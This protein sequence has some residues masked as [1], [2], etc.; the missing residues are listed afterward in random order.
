MIPHSAKPWVLIPAFEPSPDLLGCVKI[1]LE[2]GVFQQVVLVNDG[3][4][5][6]SVEMFKILSLSPE[7][8]VLTHAVN[9]GKGQALK[10]GLN[11]YL[12]HS[13][14]DSPGLVT[15]DADGQHL[16]EDIIAVTKAGMASDCF[17]LGVRDFSHGVPWRSRL[18]NILTR[19]I[20]RLFTGVKVK[21]TQTGLR[22]IPRH[23]VGNHIC[24][25]HDRFEYEFA[26]LVSE[27]FELNEKL[28]QVPISTVYIH[29]NRS[30]HFHPIRDSLA[31][32][33]V[34]L[35]F[36]SLSFIS[37]LLD[38]MVFSV[39]FFL[40]ARTLLSFI[41]ARTV[42]VT[43][44]FTFSRRWVFRVRHEFLRQAVKYLFTVFILMFFTYYVTF[45][46]AKTFGTHV[47]IGKMISEGGLFV[48]SYLI[49][50]VFIFKKTCPPIS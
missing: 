28:A 24:I 16:T 41:V 12:I 20:F 35:K 26:V 5:A 8:T 18:G 23:R 36:T 38:Y 13:H 31:I 27:S 21:D 2:S 1:L 6:S 49:Q 4:S 25:A 44:N 43:F 47:L 50:R 14:P 42:A 39:V 7:I 19:L 3:S 15:A 29:D 9:R 17:T 40:S 30:S 32:Y 46:L 45:W 10:T 34:F 33:G 37:S 22:Y 48:L 11:Y